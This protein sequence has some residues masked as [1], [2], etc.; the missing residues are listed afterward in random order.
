M[1]ACD[2]SGQEQWNQLGSDEDRQAPQPATGGDL[3]RTGHNS[4]ARKSPRVTQIDGITLSGKQLG[5]NARS[6][7]DL[8][9]NLDRQRVSVVTAPGWLFGSR[10]GEQAL[11][12]LTSLRL[13]GHASIAAAR[14]FHAAAR[15]PTANVMRC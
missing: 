6:A 10:R 13:A 11:A 7:A 14:R 1:S 4:T 15:S 12:G 8:G 2:A 5:E 9:G 3:E